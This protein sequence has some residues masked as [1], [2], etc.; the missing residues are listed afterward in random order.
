MP[1]G[2]FKNTINNNQGTMSPLEFNYPVSES[3]EYANTTE[4]QEN[5]L[6]SSFMKMIMLFKAYMNNFFE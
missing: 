4:E 2:Q 5:D 6:I 3:L 1:R